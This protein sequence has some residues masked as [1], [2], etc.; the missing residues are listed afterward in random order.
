MKRKRTQMFYRRD[1]QRDE[2]CKRCV[3]SATISGAGVMCDYIGGVKHRRPCRAKD[4]VAEGV[5]K[6]RKGV[7][8]L[9]LKKIKE[10]Y[11]RG[12]EKCRE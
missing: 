6:P 11:G 10:K 8:E 2:V 1:E 9:E 4:C 3:Y 5:F 12:E 7:R